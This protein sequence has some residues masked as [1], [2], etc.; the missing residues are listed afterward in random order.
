MSGDASMVNSGAVTLAT[1][2]VTAG[3]YT[4]ITVNAKGLATAGTSMAS[5]DV[6][7][8]L[9]FTPSNAASD[10]T[11]ALTSTKIFVGNASNIATAVNMTG[12]ASIT[13][14]G[15]VSVVKT[16]A[17]LANTIL[18]L[19]GSSIGTMKALYLPTVSGGVTLQ[20]S[21]PTSANYSLTYP[22]ALPGSNG[23]VLATSTAGIMSWV[24][25]ATSTTGWMIG[26]NTVGA[27]AA[28]GNIDGYDLTIKTNN[29]TRMTFNATTGEV[30]VANQ[31]RG[32]LG[33]VSAPT[34]GNST[35]YTT[36][37]FFPTSTTIGFTVN[38]TSVLTLSSTGVTATVPV[39]AT[40]VVL[41]GTSA[42][43]G[44]ACSTTGELARDSSGDV[45]ICK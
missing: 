38:G 19:D 7:T 22:N 44:A 25:P 27:A 26:G 15:V 9:G 13:N 33:S 24:T 43:D 41:S 8:A 18:S 14:A 4:K 40:T 29:V 28:I 6:I 20:S 16:T 5:S 35:A 34:Y 39:T 37:M 45:Y 36:G 11:N 42:T 12:D 10:L 31:T 23:M 1:T 21:S 30:V 32:P 2:G 17:G 3:T